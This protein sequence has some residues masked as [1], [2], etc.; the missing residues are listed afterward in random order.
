MTDLHEVLHGTLS[1]NE[2][3]FYSVSTAKGDGVAVTF[4]FSFVGEGK[5]YLQTGDIHIFIRDADPESTNYGDLTEILDDLLF[6]TENTVTLPTSVPSPIDGNSNITIRRIMPKDT[7]FASVETDAIF[8][9]EVLNNSFL[10]SLYVVHEALDGFLS[11]GLLDNTIRVSSSDP[12]DRNGLILPLNR[13][14]LFLSFNT[15][16]TVKLT[17]GITNTND[18][19]NATINDLSIRHTF[20]TIAEFKS[21]DKV[22]QDGKVIHLL[23]RGADFIKVSGMVTPNGFDI[24][25]STTVSQSIELIINN[26]TA[27]IEQWGAVGDNS[28]VNTPVLQ[29]IFDD[30]R[31]ALVIVGA[32]IFSTKTLNVKA[33]QVWHGLSAERSIFDFSIADPGT[34]G[35]L[36]TGGL[37]N[38]LHGSGFYDLRAQ[39][40]P[41]HN[42]RTDSTVGGGVGESF[43]MDRVQAYNGGGDGFNFSGDSTPLHLGHL[44]PHGNGGTGVRLNA[45]SQTH[46]QV[47]YIG[48][49]NNG[50]GLCV[51]ESPGTDA[52][53]HILGWKSERNS[54][55]NNSHTNIFEIINAQGGYVHIGSGRYTSQLATAPNAIV[56][57]TSGGSLSLDIDPISA[58][59]GLIAD[60][61]FLL[62]NL[63]TGDNVTIAEGRRKS[64]SNTGKIIGSTFNNGQITA[65][66]N[67]RNSIG[68]VKAA[69]TLRFNHASDGATNNTNVGWYNDTT[70]IAML[71]NSGTLSLSSAIRIGDVVSGPLI[72]SGSGSPEGSLTAVQGSKF[73]RIDGGANTSS[74]IKESGTG[75]TGWVAK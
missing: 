10:Q 21:F 33:K 24:I 25:G 36:I 50:E 22:F 70:L 46:V 51:I 29:H 60:Y 44:S 5:A 59:M 43:Y 35:F 38:Y 41:R 56:K 62:E 7:T 49:D 57:V 53:I 73:M 48:G 54:D 15:N 32:G 37:S 72:I 69:N 34:D 67:N 68:A 55:D 61:E 12:V 71:G 4:P 52:N 31:I 11:E 30:T 74:Y 14:N 8:R 26:G 47:L 65:W 19:G 23:D 28:F 45:E 20:N 58:G 13:G 1:R 9:R 75:N 42:F 63:I 6:P 40:A 39:K 17:E 66:T 3:G 2:S 64:Y 16:G 27:Y 18:V